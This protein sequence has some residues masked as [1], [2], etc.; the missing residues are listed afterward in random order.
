[1][2]RKFRPA[3]FVGVVSFAV[4]GRIGGF[5]YRARRRFVAWLDFGPPPLKHSLAVGGVVGLCF[6]FFSKKSLLR[7]GMRFFSFGKK[8]KKQA[9]LRHIGGGAKSPKKIFVPFSELR[10]SGLF[11]VEGGHFWGAPG[12][13]KN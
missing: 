4:S 6:F 5:L 12:G 1:V 10:R 3:R 13:R 7:L 2:P 11:F 9:P 8:G